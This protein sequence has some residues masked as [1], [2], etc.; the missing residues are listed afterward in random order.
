MVAALRAALGEK[1]IAVALYGS[2]A[3]GDAGRGSD[4]DLLVIARDLRHG[5]DQMLDPRFVVE[6]YY[7]ATPPPTLNSAYARC[8]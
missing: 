3:R 4:V 8:Q 6:R 2:W 1:L 5:R 7:W